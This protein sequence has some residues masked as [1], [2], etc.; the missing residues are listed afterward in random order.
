M[1]GASLSEGVPPTLSA[2]SGWTEEQAASWVVETLQLPAEQAR[3]L[4]AV[5][6]EEEFD[7]A[8]LVRAVEGKPKGLRKALANVL[9][10]SEADEAVQTL[11]GA[12]LERGV[13]SKT[14]PMTRS[15][16]SLNIKDRLDAGGEWKAYASPNSNWWQTEMADQVNRL[17]AAA[18]IRSSLPDDTRKE[19]PDLYP[20]LVVLGDGNTGK[21]TV[22]N[23]FAEFAFS[24][25]TDGVCTRRPV[26]LQLRPVQ[27]SNR[28]RMQAENLLAICTMEDKEDQHEQE[29]KFRRDH[30]E[31]DEDVLRC[32]VEKRASGEAQ[33][34]TASQAAF[35]RLYIMDELV[36]TIEA[37]QM[38]YFDLLDLPG[39]DNRS[40]KPIEMVR[41][42]INKDTLARTF[43]LI[44][45]EH[46]KGDTQLMHR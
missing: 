42:E 6:F 11:K 14:A 37:D 4:G 44:F 1:E 19:I 31:V 38:I 35:D 18:R 23:R 12:R 24:A 33:G 15:S 43:V 40:R 27:A 29:F 2:M 7:G 28:G 3:R 32:A 5:F 36:I 25:V 9:S 46:K 21:S 34:G 41:K 13:S 45:A 8:D 17:R 39:L 30:R 16:A 22:L 10:A 20:Q 26:R